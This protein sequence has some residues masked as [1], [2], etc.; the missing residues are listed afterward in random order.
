M[1]YVVQRMQ[2]GRSL[3]I[4]STQ[5]RYEAMAVYNALTGQRWVLE[6]HETG[7]QIIRS[8]DDDGQAAAY[9]ANNQRAEEPA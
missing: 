6:I 5:S 9:A 7:G 4:L 8:S 2:D 3:T 1:T